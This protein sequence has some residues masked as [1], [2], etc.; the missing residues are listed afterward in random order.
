VLGELAG[1]V[2]PAAVPGLV[3]DTCADFFGIRALES[4]S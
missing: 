3:H 2:G 4:A 1:V